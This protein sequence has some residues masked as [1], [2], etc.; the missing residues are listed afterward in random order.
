M[1]TVINWG[2]MVFASLFIIA[3]IT[4]AFLDLTAE[5][6]D[7]PRGYFCGI[8]S[9]GWVYIIYKIVTVLPH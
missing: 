8:L 7:Y 1:Q 4:V 2:V 6:Y 5:E 3:T 9:A